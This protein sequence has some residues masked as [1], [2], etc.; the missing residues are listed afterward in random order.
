MFYY[1]CPIV[2]RVACTSAKFTVLTAVHTPSVCLIFQHSPAL[3]HM[4][5]TISLFLETAA[6]V[7]PLA[8]EHTH[9]YLLELLFF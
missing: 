1:Y 2:H 9:T 7:T 4:P 8:L 3:Q 5:L 6:L